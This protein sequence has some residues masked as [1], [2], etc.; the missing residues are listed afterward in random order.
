MED[1]R[2]EKKGAAV[3]G[4]ENIS[5]NDKVYIKKSGSK[6]SLVIEATKCELDHATL[7]GLLFINAAKNFDPLNML[8]GHHKAQDSNKA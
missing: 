5:L 8:R 3:F 6:K 4:G 7:L 2:V 1:C